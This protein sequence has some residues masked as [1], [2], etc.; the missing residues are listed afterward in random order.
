LDNYTLTDY[1][2]RSPGKWA[3][4]FTPPPTSVTSS[5]HSRWVWSQ[6]GGFAS[7]GFKNR[8]AGIVVV[9]DLSPGAAFGLTQ[10]SV[11]TADG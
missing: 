4:L 9:Y 10:R 5:Y 6:V 3:P 2:W 8:A 11:Y 1:E 7:I